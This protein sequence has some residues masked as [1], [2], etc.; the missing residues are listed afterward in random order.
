VFV[1]LAESFR[2][3]ARQV[4]DPDDLADALADALARNEPALLTAKVSEM[5]DRWPY[6][7]L[8]RVRG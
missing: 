3:A 4:A 1:R 2:V 5:P 8:R 7:H 6:I